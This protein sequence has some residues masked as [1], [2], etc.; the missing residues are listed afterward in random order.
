[1]HAALV[2][3]AVVVGLLLFAVLFGAVAD[4][5]NPEDEVG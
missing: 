5:V 4:A 3:L 1:M 2:A